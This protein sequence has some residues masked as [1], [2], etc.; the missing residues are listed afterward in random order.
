MDR[1]TQPRAAHGA[2]QHRWWPSPSPSRRVEVTGQCATLTSAGSTPVACSARAIWRARN[3]RGSHAP[4]PRYASPDVRHTDARHPT[5]ANESGQHALKARRALRD[6]YTTRIVAAS[7]RAFVPKNDP[8][9]SPRRVDVV[10]PRI[11]AYATR[12]A[13]PGGHG[14]AVTPTSRA[15]RARRSSARA[16]P[17]DRYR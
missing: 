17:H 11:S 8:A 7:S 12:A 6:A 2:P 10:H 13:S 15:R 1:R 5:R 3:A 9:L 4:L 14:G 16:R